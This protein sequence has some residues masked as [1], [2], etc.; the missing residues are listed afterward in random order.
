MN[1]IPPVV[2]AVIVCPSCRGE[3]TDAPG[4]LI[5]RAEKLAYPVV[6]GVPHLIKECATAHSVTDV[7]PA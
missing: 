3:L 1:A 2:R 5:C 4:I 6:K 7:R